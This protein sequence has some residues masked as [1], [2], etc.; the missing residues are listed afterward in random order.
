MSD[1]ILTYGLHN[2]GEYSII[3]NKRSRSNSLF[4][5]GRPPYRNDCISC[6]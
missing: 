3:V 5:V 4:H 2:R 6:P 1:A